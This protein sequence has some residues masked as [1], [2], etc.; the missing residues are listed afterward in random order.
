MNFKYL[1]ALL[2][3]TAMSLV[4]ATPITLNFTSG[5]G[6]GTIGNSLT[7]SN[8]GVTATVTS[9]STPTAA[10]SAAF[11]QAATGR[12]SSGLGVCNGSSAGSETTANCID[13]QH[14]MDNSGRLDFILFQFSQAVSGISLGL[15]PFGSIHD[16]DISYWSGNSASPVSLVGQTLAG[17][18]GLGF[19][20]QLDNLTSSTSARTANLTSGSVN[21]LL[22]SANLA[23]TDTFCDY[24]KV[25]SLA[26]STSSAV[27]EP[28]TMGLMG[29]ALA[30]LGV[31]RTRKRS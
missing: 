17:L 20:G 12:W 13:P 22:I 19:G 27:P 25:G 2:T 16:S 28:A 14:T 31:M 15:T 29:L 30:G 10:S 8:G 11:S 9:W 6:V 4:N 1:G 26:A 23:N 18:G 21:M 3:V 5:G 7:Y 24:I